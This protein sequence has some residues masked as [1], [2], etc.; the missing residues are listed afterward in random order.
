MIPVSRMRHTF[1]ALFCVGLIAT[2]PRAQA[3]TLHATEAEQPAA[4]FLDA[5]RYPFLQDAWGRFAGTVVF[6]G[7]AGRERFDLS[8]ALRLGPQSVDATVTLA[9]K[10]VYRVVQ[11][12]ARGN[13][14]RAV[15]TMPENESPPHLVDLGLRPEDITLSFIYW[16]LIA[17]LAPA[18]IYGQRCRVME[19]A[20]PDGDGH[21]RVWF[22]QAYYFPLRALWFERGANAPWR[23]LEFRSF[24]K[25]D[26][27]MWFMKTIRLSG[28]GWRTQVTFD[29]AELRALIDAEPPADLFGTT[30]DGPAAPGTRQPA[31]TVE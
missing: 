21:V 25:F 8:L 2:V 19:L 9:G 12:H 7:P 31:T 1:C 4:A 6:S 30:P 18:T 13:Q 24:R 28:D 29:D 16:P 3:Q 27:D 22:S 11:E 26:R 23:E 20:H 10:N 14:P 17:E 5:V 15:L